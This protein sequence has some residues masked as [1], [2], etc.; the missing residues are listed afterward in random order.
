MWWEQQTLKCT[1]NSMLKQIGFPETLSF[2]GS[3]RY[4]EMESNGIT[5]S[6]LLSFAN[7]WD[8]RVH[9]VKNFPICHLYSMN[10]RFLVEKL[11]ARLIMKIS[12]LLN[13]FSLPPVAE[14]GSTIADIP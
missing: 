3:P 10:P 12:T 13:Y 1:R 7:A 6:S 14:K 8:V 4:H 11:W 5:F 9:V 2:K